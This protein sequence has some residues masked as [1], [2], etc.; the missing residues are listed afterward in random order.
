MVMAFYLNKILSHEG[1]QGSVPVYLQVVEILESGSWFI[2]Q[3]E[4]IT[5]METGMCQIEAQKSQT[6]QFV[7]YSLVLS[8]Q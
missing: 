5:H 3:V 8:F 4:P 2:L 1:T 6:I 7:F